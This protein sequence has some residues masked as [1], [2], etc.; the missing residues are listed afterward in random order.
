MSRVVLVTG[1]SSGLGR[2]TARALAQAGYDLAAH[3]RSHAEQAAEV[4]EEAR[5]LGR[6]AL[7]LQADLAVEQEVSLLYRRIDEELGRIDAVVNS[8]GIGLPRTLV[9]ALELGPLERMFATNVFGLMLSCR[10]AV[11]RLAKSRGGQGGVIINLSSMAATIGGRPGNAAY[12]AS[13]AAVDAF[14]IGLAKEVAADGI[15]VISVRP[16]MFETEMTARDLQDP[17]A[18]ATVRA[19][20]P[21]GRAGVPA[22]VAQPIAFLLSD[23]ASFI[24]GA[25]IDISGGGF[26]IARGPAL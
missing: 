6:R 4:V 12:A 14:S 19:S 22:E 8:A 5:K 10:E 18:L 21:L 11:K 1:A 26:H 13:K 2:A 17:H 25:C 15:R 16:G 7:A 3:Y 20:I 23:A 24:T 9:P